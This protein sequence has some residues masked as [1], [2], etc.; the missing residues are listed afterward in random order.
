MAHSVPPA[1][2]TEQVAALFQVSTTTIMR[3][4]NRGQLPGT[5]RTPGGHLRF[6]A[7]RIHQM[8]PPPLT[9]ESRHV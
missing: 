6:D 9:E 8:F 1:Y 7:S 2:T 4:A 3:W 5:F